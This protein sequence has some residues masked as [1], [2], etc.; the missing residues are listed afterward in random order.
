MFS[1]I[2]IHQ[3]KNT[4]SYF[5]QWRDIKIGRINQKSDDQNMT[6]FGQRPWPD[7]YEN[8]LDSG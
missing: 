4:K 3:E 1:K 2:G 5:A 8:R 6:A 7:L